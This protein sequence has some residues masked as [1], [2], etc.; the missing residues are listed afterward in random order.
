MEFDKRLL[1]SFDE[2]NSQWLTDGGQYE[3]KI[4]A[5]SR[6]IRATASIKVAAATEKAGDVL[7][8][9]AKLNLLHQ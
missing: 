9:N 4:G 2:A 7:K 1:A 8:P 6:D 5:S 3:L